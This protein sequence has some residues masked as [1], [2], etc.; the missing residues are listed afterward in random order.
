MTYWRQKRP[1]AFRHLLCFGSASALIK[2]HDH[3]QLE[4]ERV[5]FGLQFSHSTALLREV[6]AGIPRQEPGGRKQCRDHGG[7][8][9]TGLLSLIFIH[10]GTTCPGVTPAIMGCTLT[11][12]SLIKKMQCCLPIGQSGRNIFSPEALSPKMTVACIT[13]TETQHSTASSHISSH[14]GPVASYCQACQQAGLPT[15]PSHWPANLLLR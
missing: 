14:V 15:E 2:Y 9:L 5:C 7:V 12:E 4:E 10:P 1:Q 11:Y 6:R 8:L 3:K 13:L